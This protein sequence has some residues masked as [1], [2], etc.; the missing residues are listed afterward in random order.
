MTRVQVV[1][2]VIPPIA[3]SSRELEIWTTCGPD[4]QF[5]SPMQCNWS[6]ALG[7][8]LVANSNT[9]QFQVRSAD[10]SFFSKYGWGINAPVAIDQ[11]GA[12]V[13]VARQGGAYLYQ[14][15]T[16]FVYVDALI[17]IN[18]IRMIDAANL[19]THILVTSNN[20]TDHHGLR[21]VKKSDMTVPA[22]LSLLVDGSGNGQF[23]DP[24]GV[25]Y[26]D[27]KAY[28]CDFDNRRIQVIAIDLVTPALTYDSQVALG[29]KPYDL[30]NDGVNWYVLGNDG[31]LY[32]YDMS[33]TDA[34][35]TSVSVVGYSL[36][37]I[38]DQGDGYGATLCIVDNTNSH[39]ERRKCSDLSAINSVGSSGDGSGTLFD[40][41]ITGA[42]GVWTDDEGNQYSVASAANISKNGFSAAF[43]RN[44]S[45][46]R[47][48]WKG[49]RES[50]TA[51]DATDDKITSIK[52]LNKCINLT[53]LKVPT[54]PGLALNLAEISAKMATLWAFGCGT[55]IVGS[56][57][58]MLSLAAVNLRENAASADQV[59][60][61]INDLW[62]N[63]D[64][65]VPGSA[66][67]NGSNAAPSGIYQEATPP[68]TGKEKAY[69]LVENYGWSLAT[70]S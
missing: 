21:L 69:D 10:I 16:A 22:G 14:F 23:D 35:K 46:H 12:Y 41:L 65:M 64:L 27:G 58:H 17:A 39:I 15:S 62:Q 68:T 44:G 48:I 70:T 59:D 61:W 1:R 11:Y 51:I 56:I 25:K 60:S 13:Y 43:F 37:I 53:S 18:S 26:Y 2:G 6:A 4:D 66:N 42:A 55:G 49:P 34:T 5:S 32:K 50:I 67:F 24:L 29:Y 47:V 20:G 8:V 45:M 57:R 52:G 9:A 36:C 33:F 31:K 38:P 3:K 40:T 63:R 28:V 54:N 30:C 7:K 19:A